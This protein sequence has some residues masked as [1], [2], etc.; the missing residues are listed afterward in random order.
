M[1]KALRQHWPE[2]LIEAAALGTFM[3]SAVFFTA[4]LNHPSSP[5]QIA[6]H[7]F[8]QRALIGLAMGLTAIGLIYS[9]WGQRSGAHMNPA[10]TLTFLRLGKI[11][12][13]DA[14]FYIV[15]QI[16]GGIAGMAIAVQLFGRT[17]MHE[18]VNYVVTVPGPSGPIP[19]F[20][21]EA[22]MAGVMMLMVLCA[23]NTPRLARYTG[24]LGGILVFLFITFEAP[25]SGMSINPARSFSSALPS[26]VWTGLWI[27]FTAPILGMFAAAEFFRF[28]KRTPAACPK[29]FHGQRQRC[30]F[31]GHP[32]SV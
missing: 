17:I 21:A 5:L 9:P 28:L 27:Y 26:G 2:Y 29:Y 15:A 10:L 18:S 1:R 3:L 8:I 32:S 11:K 20:V 14:A 23:T 24:F 13:L 22:A 6:H 19:A 16:V 7:D 31:C 25:I 30:I 12:P 4:L